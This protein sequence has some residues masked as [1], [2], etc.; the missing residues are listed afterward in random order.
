MTDS[1]IVQKIDEYRDELAGM[2]QSNAPI[3]PIKVSS[4]AEKLAILNDMLTD[5]VSA[6]RKRLLDKEHELWVE[7][8]SKTSATAVD[9]LI[10]ME[11]REER[12]YYEFLQNKQKSVWS[13][14]NMTKTY[15]V[16]CR[17]AQENV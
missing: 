8:S 15:I 14:L 10:R 1:E 2:V 17:E 3:H 16:D 11:T 4:I 9:R 6:A 12:V 5:K 13:F 7:N